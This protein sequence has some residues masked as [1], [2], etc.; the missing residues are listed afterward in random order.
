MTV[1]V[2]DTKLWIQ[3]IKAHGKTTFIFDEL[4]ELG[5]D[6]NKFLKKAIARRFIKPVDKVIINKSQKVEVTKWEITLL[7]M[8][9][10]L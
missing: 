10:V 6:Q 5:L 8:D 3:R 9:K 1:A 4:R 7:K 2:Y